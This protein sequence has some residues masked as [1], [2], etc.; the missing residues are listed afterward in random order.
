MIP[1]E[2]YARYAQMRVPRYTSYPPAPHFSPAVDHKDYRSWL[3]RIPAADPVSIYL[4]IPFCR[5]MCWYCGCNT[6]VTRRQAPISRYVATLANEIALVAEQ[7]QARPNVGHLHWGGG[8]PTLLSAEDID[9]LMLEL[10]RALDFDGEAEIAVEVDPRT[11][12]E[13]VAAAFARNGVN[14]ASLGVQTF[15]PAVQAAIN[16]IQ[17]FEAT[18]AVVDMLRRSGVSALNFDLLYGLPLQTMASCIDTAKLA[19]QLRPD[20]IA[21]FGYAHV[22]SFKPHQRKIDET[23]LPSA[24]ERQEQFAAMAEFFAREGYVQVGLDHFALPDDPLVQAAAGGTLRRNFQGYTTD[25]CGT[26]LAFGASA[27]GQLREGFVQNAVRIPEYQRHLE[28]GR[29]PI[30]RGYRLSD[31]DRRRGA[32]IE[33]LMCNYQA[34]LSE[35]PAALDQLEADGLIRRSGGRIE[36][37]EEARPLVRTVAAAFDAFLPNSTATHALA[38]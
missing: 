6:T 8:S 11:L 16:R 37:V 22:P 14:R 23:A 5:E 18:A 19:L 28:N 21:L 15:D 32:I 24:A 13:P 20:R 26:L 34:E 4:H 10:A 9:R 38:V 12:T 33:Q 1:P 31:D 25:T 35:V 7:L 17:S 27:I 29:L 30:V 2:T 3:R 36:I